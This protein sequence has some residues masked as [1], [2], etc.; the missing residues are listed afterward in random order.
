MQTAPDQCTKQPFPKVVRPESLAVYQSST[1]TTL[2]KDNHYSSNSCKDTLSLF[3]TLGTHMKKS[4]PL[5][6]IV[7]NDKNIKFFL[8][9]VKL[10]YK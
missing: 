5:Y 8:C 9:H 1:S 3:L 2:G 6:Q 7:I 4:L 10:D